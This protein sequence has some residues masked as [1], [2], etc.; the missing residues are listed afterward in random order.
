MSLTDLLAVIAIGV[1][2][3]NLMVAIRAV[4]QAN[5]AATPETRTGAIN[6]VREALHDLIQEGVVK[7][8]TPECLRKAL[9]LSAPVFSS[10]ARQEI[11]QA[12]VMAC[13]LQD[14]GWQITDQDAH[15]I[16]ALKK[17]CRC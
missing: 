11:D 8:N 9:Y 3:G 4:Q 16:V 5:K 2:V 1:F 13:R 17:T 14:V 12:Y 10:E 15:D 6:H 7:T